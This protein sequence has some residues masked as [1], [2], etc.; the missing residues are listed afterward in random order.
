MRFSAHVGL[1]NERIAAN[2]A[3]GGEI[4]HLEPAMPSQ[5]RSPPTKSVEDSQQLA[6]SVDRLTDEL[7][8]L[9]TV[10][11]SI[12]E[13]VSWVTR[14]GLPVQPVEHVHVKRMARDPCAADS[15]ERLD[16][17]RTMIHPPGQLS[18][19]GSLDIERIAEELR[20]AVETLAQEHLEPV[21]TALDEVRGALLR[22]IQAKKREAGV[23]PLSGDSEDAQDV[24]IL[25]GELD[26]AETHAAISDGPVVALPAAANPD[27]TVLRTVAN[28]PTNDETQ[29]HDSGDDDS[30]E[31]RLAQYEQ[32]CREVR[33]PAVEHS[34]GRR[35]IATA[36][37]SDSARV[38]YAI[39][40]LPVGNWAVH[41]R[42]G[43]QCGNSEGVGNSWTT[44]PT[45]PECIQK[46]LLT[47][48][49]F[50]SNQT[51]D[52]VQQLPRRE[53]LRLLRGGLFEFSEPDPVLTDPDRRVKRPR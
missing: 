22:A 53:M 39:A 5:R 51:S 26:A 38:E 24:L 21:L 13:D 25:T 11:E 4:W 8:S 6:E 40:Q 34:E 31:A 48:R 33:D 37:D 18:A 32:W 16:V 9:G 35:T 17:E 3:Q 30:S 44:F 15:N 12:R 42:Y 27:E 19:L 28:D 1:V 2:A 7:R 47:A 43:Y 49:Q 36:N 46:V 45:R 14:N 10:L 23:E 52:A 41:W 29:A 50:F 20:T